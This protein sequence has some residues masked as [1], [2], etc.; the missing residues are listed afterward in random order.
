MYE[1]DADLLTEPL[2][3]EVW[4]ELTS[5]CPFRCVFCS[6]ALRRGEG[7][8]MDFGLYRRL[9]EQLVS[10]E[11]IRLNYAGESIHYPRLREAIA[12]ARG[13]RARTELVTAFA[14]IAP[15][16]LAGLVRSGLDRL[17][18]SLHTLEARQFQE[19]YGHSSLKELQGRVEE[20]RRRAQE[21]PTPPELD[22][23]FVA[24]ERNLGQLEPLA[25]YA[26]KLGVREILV[27]PVIRRDPIPSEFATELKSEHGLT[28]SFR[29]RLRA[30]IE[31]VRERRPAVRITLG[32]P[33]VEDRTDLGE[34]PRRCPERLSVGARIRTCD[35]SPWNTAHVLANGDVVACEVHDR[36]PLGNLAGQSLREIWWGEGYRQFRRDYSNGLVGECS[37]CPWKTAY[38]PAP[39]RSSVRGVEGT[40]A[41]LLAGWHAGPDP[42]VVW[43][44]QGSAVMLAR[45]EGAQRLRVRGILPASS[46][47]L[48]IVVNGAAAGQVA[49]PGDG[50]LEFE[51]VLRVAQPAAEPWLVRF[52]ARQA[53]CPA[54]EGWSRD[55]RRLGF[56][57]IEV[58]AEAP[59]RAR[60]RLLAAL[61]L[62]PAFAALALADAALRRL[63]RCFPRR[64]FPWRHFNPGLSVV[65]P[66]RDNPALLARCLAGLAA[67][68]RGL[69]EP[70]EV[71]V[72]VNGTPPERYT[73]LRER[74]PEVRWLWFRQALGFSGAVR[75]GLR[76]AAFDWVYL[77]NNDMVLDPDA[78]RRLLPLRA[79]EVFAI[80]SQILPESPGGRREETNWTDWRFPEGLVE[81]YD[82]PPE[83]A[84][85]AYGSLYAG[86]GSSLFRRSLLEALV[87]H[88]G[89]AYEPFYWEDVEW[90]VV[91]RKLGYRVLFCPASKAVHARRATIA[92]LYAPEEVERIFRRNGYRFQLRNV[93]AAGSLAALAR[94]I[95]E[96]DRQTLIE[97]LRPG[98]FLRAAAARIRSHFLPLDDGELRA[99]RRTGD[100]CT[101]AP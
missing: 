89:G 93:T 44:K 86:G 58:A 34:I 65:I 61:V 87:A 49:H 20:F 80:A 48:D 83:E 45:P 51:R 73:G 74:Y 2:P 33:E 31:R 79:P 41:Q 94:K 72:V 100:R 90:G 60:R 46:K 24:M 5:K 15:D 21:C 57:L 47:A 63:R 16:V 9:V 6:R 32:N 96:A 53:C 54:R 19:I 95:L 39:L 4:V 3:T 43:S 28:A 81:I 13:T 38:H 78:L 75:A 64:T 70:C 12:L 84:Q 37:C 36:K 82:A 10:P 77:L 8:H 68:A 91:A 35:Q 71:I 88:A 42:G 11:V 18:V 97:L 30:E 56:A 14:S 92:K 40:D 101:I 26:E 52:R 1:P 55:A 23:A 7:E 27:C 17:T 67:A 99:V 66:E 76:R 22:F 25:A 50:L 85:D 69:A 98:A 59:A 29:T 62:L